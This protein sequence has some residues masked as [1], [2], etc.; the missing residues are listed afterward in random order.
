MDACAVAR[1]EALWTN[2]YRAG[3]PDKEAELHGKEMRQWETV[4]QVE[5]RFR[6]VCNEVLREAR[7]PQRA[8]KS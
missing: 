8:R 2:G 1:A 7:K 5:G 4:R 3:R 6:R